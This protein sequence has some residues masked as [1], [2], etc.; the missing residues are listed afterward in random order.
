MELFIKAINKV[1]AASN[2]LLTGF[3]RNIRRFNAFNSLENPLA[4]IV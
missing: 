4:A 1:L 3:K 2:T